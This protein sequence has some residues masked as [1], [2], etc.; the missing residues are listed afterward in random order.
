V[1]RSSRQSTSKQNTA[2]AIDRLRKCDYV[3]LWYFTEKDCQ[4]ADR[5]K[6][7]N[8]D[9]WDVIKTSDNCLSL[10]TTASNPQ[11]QCVERRFADTWEQ[12][13]DANHLLCR[14]LTP[15]GWLEGYARVLSS[16]WQIENH[17][18]KGIPEGKETLLLY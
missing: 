17:D 1:A 5:D 7:F 12:F 10:R 16:F 14:W 11:L 9:P 6:A 4:A 18:D 15:A 3:P 13:M 2:Y 8:D